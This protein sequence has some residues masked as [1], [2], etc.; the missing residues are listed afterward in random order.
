MVSSSPTLDL[1]IGLCTVAITVGMAAIG[2]LTMN[3]LTA[4]MMAFGGSS[5]HTVVKGDRWRMFKC[6]WA[7]VNGIRSEAFGHDYAIIRQKESWIQYHPQ[8]RGYVASGVGYHVRCK[9][10]GEQYD[11]TGLPELSPLEQL[12]LCAD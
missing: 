8:D 12:A 4:A 11:W 10:C 3:L 1:A 2:V 7:S 6:K 5:H 9:Q